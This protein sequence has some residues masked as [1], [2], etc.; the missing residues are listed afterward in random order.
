M[1]FLKSNLDLSNHANSAYPQTGPSLHGSAVAWLHAKAVLQRAG[2]VASISG[3]YD[4]DFLVTVLLCRE[5]DECGDVPL[6][7]GLV[8]VGHDYNDNGRA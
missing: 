7:P 4:F 2:S 6:H 3:N 1:A 5:G 8:L